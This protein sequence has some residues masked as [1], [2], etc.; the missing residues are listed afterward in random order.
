MPEAVLDIVA[1]YPQEQHVAEQ[2]HPA[3][4]HEHRREH[5]GGIGGRVSENCRD[6]RPFDDEGIA[7]GKLQ[8]KNQHIEADQHEGDAG[9]RAPLPIVVADRKHEALSDRGRGDHSQGREAPQ[10][11]AR[12]SA[13]LGKRMV[14]RHR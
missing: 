9:G 5:G 11:R 6:E 4:M 3:A 2:M 1:E 10:A 13:T 8:E 14:L 12:I 7:L